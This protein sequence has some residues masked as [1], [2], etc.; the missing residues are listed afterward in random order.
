MPFDINFLI[1]KFIESWKPE[2]IF[3]VD[4]EIWPNLIIKAH[5]RESLL[6]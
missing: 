6:D 3:L 4:S 1:E 2:K 5:E